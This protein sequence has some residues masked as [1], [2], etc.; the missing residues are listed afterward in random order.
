VW[1]TFVLVPGLPPFG[2]LSCAKCVDESQWTSSEFTVTPNLDVVIGILLWLC[3]LFL[4]ITG[5]DRVNTIV[6]PLY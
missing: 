3:K 4:D 1:L 2:Q 6:S 5:N